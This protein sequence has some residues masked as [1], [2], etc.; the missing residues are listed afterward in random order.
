[1]KKIKLTRGYV[2]LVDNEDF[3]RVARYKWWALV[4]PRQ[5]YACSTKPGGGK[6]YLHRFIVNE[7]DPKCLVEHLDRN[8]LNCQKKNLQ[9]KTTKSK[10]PVCQ[11]W[12]C[13]GV[14]QGS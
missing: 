2:A 1:M 5:I 8:G 7:T 3:E 9:P 12:Q 14:H 4:L 13:A 6:I 11:L 10:N